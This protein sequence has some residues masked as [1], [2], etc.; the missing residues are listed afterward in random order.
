MLMSSSISHAAGR[1]FYDGFE[2][3]TTNKWGQDD[4]RSRCQVVT[5]AADG[6]VGPKAGTRMVRCNDN[7]TLDWD[8]PAQYETLAL[9]NVS[10]TSEVFYRVWVR[11][12]LNH[13]RTGESAKKIMRIFAG[14]VGSNDMYN[15]VGVGDGQRNEGLVNG[16]RQLNTYWGDAAGDNTNSS[17]AWHKVEYYFN[18]ATGKIRVWHDGILVRDDTISFTASP[19]WKP[20]YI[21][22]NWS[23][24]HDATNYL[25]FDEI[26]VF[27]DQGAGASGLMSNATIAAGGPAGPPPAPVVRLVP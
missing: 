14:G 27:S 12:D 3:G 10:Y 6:V 1:V 19:Q 26:E 11:P 2:D 23:D 16:G 20:M 5:S 22:S 4:F 8:Q 18:Q 13:Q 7:G 9:P 25:Y 24:A 15:V 17:S 21:T